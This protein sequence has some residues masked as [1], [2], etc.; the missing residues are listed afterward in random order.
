[1]QMIQCPNCGKLT[2]FKRNL[3]FGTFFLVVI[4]GGLWLLAIPFYSLRCVTCGLTSSAARGAKGYLIIVLILIIVAM[5]G[6]FTH[7][8][9]WHDSGTTYI[10]NGP[11]ISNA[12]NDVPTQTRHIYT[13]AQIN[14]HMNKIPTGTGLAVRG[15]YVS[16]H[17]SGGWAPPNQLDPCSVLL[18]GGT[19][20]VQHGEADPRD[21]CR[22]SV[23]LQDENTNQIQY[24]ECVMSL[25]GAQAA[26]GQYS[27]KSPVQ[28][29]GTYASSLDFHIMP[30]FLGQQVGVPVLDDCALEPSQP[31]PVPTVPAPVAGRPAPPA[32]PTP[33]NIMN[34]IN[35]E[36]SRPENQSK[37]YPVDIDLESDVRK[38]L[39]TSKALKSAVITPVLL[40]R[41]VTLSGTVVDEPSRELAEEITSQVP[42][43]GKRGVMAV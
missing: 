3:G 31:L 19:V 36:N 34:A 32:S 29:H 16:P 21:Y 33:K 4:T 14:A 22:F 28:A 12:K 17:V 7:S 40:H 26:K 41:E 6:V 25:E 24:L 27:Y 5:F 38:A 2:G 30:T 23:M 20:R 43:V 11:S 8:G 1:M 37:P 39:S 10:D 9:G 18:Y 15:F 42:G 13:V 35:A